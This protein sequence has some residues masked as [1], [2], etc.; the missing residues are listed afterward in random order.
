MSAL[1]PERTDSLRTPT[2]PATPHRT[3]LGSER[4]GPGP[5]RVLFRCPPQPAQR[6]LRAPLGAVSAQSRG[7]CRFSLPLRFHR[8]LVLLISGIFFNLFLFLFFGLWGF[9]VVTGFQEPEPAP[10]RRHGESEPLVPPAWSRLTC[11]DPDFLILSE[12][13]G[14]SG[15]TKRNFS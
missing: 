12:P 15:E 3:G 4:P 14:H 7:G 11:R 10:P 5:V 6:L 8:E 9:R 13:A 2:H 1:S